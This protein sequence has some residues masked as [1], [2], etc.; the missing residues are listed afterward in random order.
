MLN[1]YTTCTF[2][3]EVDGTDERGAE[4]YVRA[5]MRGEG[6]TSGRYF[7]RIPMRTKCCFI[8]SSLVVSLIE[9]VCLLVSGSYS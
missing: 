8:V 3:E 4:W 7:I 5:A 2:D 6:C 9:L 1:K